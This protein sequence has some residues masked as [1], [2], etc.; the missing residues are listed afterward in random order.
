M[1]P[2]AFPRLSLQERDLVCRLTC[3]AHL[4]AK[5]YWTGTTT[6]AGACV[7]GALALYLVLLD[8]YDKGRLSLPPR[9]VVGTFLDGRTRNMLK[10]SSKIF[11]DMNYNHAW[12]MLGG[13]VYDPTMLQFADTHPFFAGPISFG[14]H[15]PRAFNM[16]A[17][18]M[19][20]K[21]PESQ[22][23]QNLTAQIKSYIER[24]MYGQAPDL[25][26]E[27]CLMDFQPHV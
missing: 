2:G 25:C 16:R 26:V 11:N 8:E 24:N 1:H 15:V 10:S 12:V 7:N 27:K 4:G 3:L 13:E 17:I 9:Y 23:P 14:L 20:F 21:F 5:E 19:A 22:L 6:L 18:Q